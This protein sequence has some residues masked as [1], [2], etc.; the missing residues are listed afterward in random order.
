LGRIGI[1]PT[2]SGSSRFIVPSKVNLT[3]RSPSG[4]ALA[5]FA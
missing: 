5:T 3:R 4:S 2:I 1:C